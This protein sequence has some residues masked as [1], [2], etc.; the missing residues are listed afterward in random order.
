MAEGQ[1]DC[2]ASA[3][4]SV[5]TPLSDEEFRQELG[6]AI[7]HLRAYGRSLTGNADMA[8]DLVQDTLLKAWR[9]RARFSAGTNMRA[10]TFIILR[11]T[12][13]SQRRRDKF[14]ADWDDVTADRL[15]SRPAGQDEQ[16]HLADVQRA[17]MQLPDS[18]REAL[19][20]VGA[21]GFSY[22]EAADICGVA[23]GT[24][25]SR[26][27]RAR[28]ALEAI[29]D[30]GSGKTGAARSAD[31]MGDILRDVDQL[32]GSALGEAEE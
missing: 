4:D 6:E 14:S 1:D 9:A 30:D 13:L 22:E 20:L 24:I 26:V 2:C 28:A 15:L 12:F 23:L 19:V 31:P 10:W 3:A 17:L 18:Q 27:A 5:G 8:D 25:K 7:P 29:I 11:N 21:G 16:I 32:A